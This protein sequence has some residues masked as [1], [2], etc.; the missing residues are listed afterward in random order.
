MLNR[1]K[2]EVFVTL[3][4]VYGIRASPEGAEAFDGILMGAFNREGAEEELQRLYPEWGALEVK[5]V[6]LDTDCYSMD[7]E[8]F[9]T[10]AINTTE[11]N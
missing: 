10:I 3:T 11:E 9:I 6:E 1:R 5:S 8:E 7:L 4:H 2:I